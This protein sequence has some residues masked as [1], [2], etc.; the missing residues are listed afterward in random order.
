MSYNTVYE[1]FYFQL[2]YFEIRFKNAGVDVLHG[3]LRKPETESRGSADAHVE[4]SMKLRVKSFCKLPK[5]VINS[6]EGSW[7]K[8]RICAGSVEWFLPRGSRSNNVYCA[9]QGLVV[10]TCGSRSN[11]VYSAVQGSSGSGSNSVYSAVQGPIVSTCG[12]RSNNVYSSVQCPLVST[13]GSRSYIVH[14]AV[15]C[16]LVSTWGS[17]SYSV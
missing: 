17:R 13:W 1:S 11:S 12:S 6:P 4:P 3:V 8:R 14:S 7:Y 2:Q 9:V 5:R 15:Q 16:P 10:S